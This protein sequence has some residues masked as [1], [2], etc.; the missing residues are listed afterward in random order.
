MKAYK[1]MFSYKYAADIYEPVLAY[2]MKDIIN[3]VK[4]AS[5][6]SV[7]STQDNI[8]SGCTPTDISFFAKRAGH[9]DMYGINYES[10]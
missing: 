5:Y 1:V 2:D 3:N 8:V 6:L 7:L 9:I 10:P 4:Y